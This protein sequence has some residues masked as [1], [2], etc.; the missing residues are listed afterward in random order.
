MNSGSDLEKAKRMEGELFISISKRGAR[1]IN[2]L[3]SSDICYAMFYPSV[4]YTT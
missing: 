4:K 3:G 1:K 2:C